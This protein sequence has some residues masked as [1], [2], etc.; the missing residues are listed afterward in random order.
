MKP[1]QLDK[2]PTYVK[3]HILMQ[4]QTIKNLQAEVE[5][6][7]NE[8]RIKVEASNTVVVEGIE[9]ETAIKPFSE[10]EFRFTNDPDHKRRKPS[11]SVRLDRD[12]KSVQVMGSDALIIAPQVSNVIH[13]CLKD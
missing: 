1:E 5:W 8:D 3:N 10:V 13:I 9:H 12:G 2:L 6:R 7:K 4:A 11:V